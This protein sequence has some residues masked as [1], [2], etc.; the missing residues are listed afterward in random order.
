MSNTVTL[1]Q[2]AYNKLLNRL[3]LVENLLK[4]LISKLDIEPPEGSDDWW[5]WAHK[6][7]LE[8][9]KKG[10][11]YELKSKNDIDDFFNHI[12]DDTYVFDKF[13]HKG[14]KTGA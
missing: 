1:S 10:E 5:D 11:Y 13:H 8:D 3:S 14:K 12:D 9:M 7:G 2:S 4:H 6:K